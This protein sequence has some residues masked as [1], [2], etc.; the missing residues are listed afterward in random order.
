MNTL[1]QWRLPDPNDAR[2]SSRK[3]DNALTTV[4]ADTRIAGVKI[5]FDVIDTFTAPITAVGEYLEVILSPKSRI[6]SVVVIIELG[7]KESMRRVESAQK[8][9]VEASASSLNTNNKSQENNVP[10]SPPMSVNESN[11][12]SMSVPL[13]TNAAV[14]SSGLGNTSSTP[15]T[16]TSI[17]L[18]DTKARGIDSLVERMTS[19]TVMLNT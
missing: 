10:P 16:V 14:K 13:S 6:V 3:G 9:V 17:P 4:P 7:L 15:R 19:V 5:V 12:N 18:G 11:R 8:H 2:R 1:F